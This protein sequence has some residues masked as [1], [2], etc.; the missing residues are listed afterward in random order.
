[1]LKKLKDS[2]RTA[3]VSEFVDALET[4]LIAENTKSVRAGLD[5]FDKL[6]KQL[7][8]EE[9]W[10][11]IFSIYGQAASAF[12]DVSGK[13][14][15]REIAKQQ[16][17][18]K[19]WRSRLLLLEVAAFNEN[20]SFPDATFLALKDKHPTVVR[21]SLNYLSRHRKIRV[22]EAVVERYVELEKKGGKNPD[23]ELSR[24]LLAFRSAL[25]RLMRVD[26]PAAADWKNYIDIRKKG[27]KKNFFKVPGSSRKSDKTVLTLFG[28]E[29]TGKNIAFVLDISGSMKT[30]DPIPLH[31][32][33]KGRGRTTTEPNGPKGIPRG[34]VEERRR[35][36]R[37]KKELAKVVKSLP[38][39]VSFN[40]ISY[41]TEVESWKDNL[42][43]A[44]SNSK[45]AAIDF[46]QG[47][48][49]KGITV[50]DEALEEAFA[51][52]RVDT[53]YLIT[54]GA[55][56]HVGTTGPG[57]PEDAPGLMAEIHRRVKVLNFLRDVRVFCLG[58]KGAE[59]DFLKKLAKDNKGKFV[60]IE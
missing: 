8:D 27:K 23:A 21:R 3:D 16:E 43:K 46:V 49:A 13:S 50:T 31:D 51:D 41:S 38:D 44:D 11:T 33:G 14:S 39:G 55:P 28:A 53:V 56:T 6:V 42:I 15:L 59:V 7:E 10:G 17:K 1:A 22:V 58:F 25:N 35:I 4:V 19:S 40:V 37:A 30:T 5:N 47:L 29:V 57:L 9:D 52:L 18:S 2:A 36:T 54:D 34:R 45:K 60:A 20:I 24:T 12:K 32:R 48:N 26:L